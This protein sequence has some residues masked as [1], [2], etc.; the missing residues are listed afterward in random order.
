MT[1]KER[2]AVL[3]FL[4]ANDAPAEPSLAD[5]RARL[6]SLA[7]F[8]PVPDGT[9]VEPATIGGVKGEWVRARRARRDAALL[10]LHGGGY[11]TGSPASHRHLAAALSEAA[12]IGVFVA[13]YRLAPEHPFPAAVD[14]AVAAYKGLL[15]SGMAADKLAIA[16]D[17]AGGGLTIAT[18]VAAR[19]KNLPMPACAVA[20]SPWADLSQGGESY[21][22][23]LKRDPMVGKDGLDA[24]A[25]AYLGGA[26][27]KTPLAS[28]LFADLKG[29][30]PLLLQVGTEEALYD[31]TTGLKARAE[32]AGV[33]VS[34][35]S[36]GGMVHVWHIFHP[37]LSEARDAIARIGAFIKTHIA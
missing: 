20:I 17:S 23:R 7:N 31:D 36:W 33:D 13:D 6:D 22:T 24:M 28:P 18:L 3:A 21:R 4:K 30:P 26:D 15:D 1:V 11:V 9:E 16:G 10:Y 14:D 34:A 2:E 29:L 5:Q 12:G 25:A 37:L 35:E 32:A 8:F 27:A 19:G